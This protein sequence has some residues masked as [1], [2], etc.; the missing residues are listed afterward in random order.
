[1]AANQDPKKAQQFLSLQE[2]I[3]KANAEQERILKESVN[4]TGATLRNL[5]AQY[6]TQ[7]K[8]KASAKAASDYA[9]GFATASAD[10]NKYQA[11]IAANA[12]NIFKATG[13]VEDVQ[14][15]IVA[16]ESELVSIQ[17][18]G[19]AALVD[20]M[21]MRINVLK[22]SKQTLKVQQQS[23]KGLGTINDMLGDNV[24]SLVGFL[25]KLPGGNHLV[26]MMG[27]DKLKEGIAAALSEAAMVNATMGGGLKGATAGAKAFGKSLLVS[28][29][30]IALIAAGI[31]G[32][33]MVFKQVSHQ[34]H[35]LSHNTGLTYAQSKLLVKE[36]NKQVASLGNQ[37]S[38]QKDILAVQQES[39]KEFG[40]MGMMTTQQAGA[41][42]DM[43]IA[44]GY[45][46]Q[47]AAK[48]NNAFMSM[49]VTA[50][51]AASAQQ[52]LAAE[53][54]KAGVNVGA[55]TA[56]VAANAK[57][58]AKYFG[59]N[60]K[61]L[62]KAAIE[63]AKM[64]MS[65]ATMA[66]VSDSLLDFEN[67]ISAQFELQA[68]T[69]K[70]MNFDLARQLALEGDIA[71]ATAAVMDQVGSIHD[72]NKMDVL[73]RKKLAQATGMDVDELQK[74]LV[75]KDK[76]GD[77]TSDEL[78]SMNALGLSA[79][80]MANMSSEDLQNK[81]ASKQASE[82]TA[83][84]FAAMKAQLVNALMPAAEAI[85]GIFSALS[86][87]FKVLG[88]AL[89]IAF[90]PLTLAGKAL[91][92]IMGLMEKFKGVTMVIGGLVATEYALRN[93]MLIQSKA[94]AGMQMAEKTW[95]GIKNAFMNKEGIQA[96]V[97]NAFQATKNALQKSELGQLI[98]IG[99]QK[100]WQGVMAAKDLVVQGSIFAIEQGK[101]AI[102]Y[103]INTAK[104]IANVISMG[105]IGPLMASAGAAIAAAIPAIFTGFGMIPFGLGIPL[106]FAA[107]AGLIGL[108]G[109]MSKGDDV[110]SSPSGGSGYGSRV[111]FGPEGAISF[112]NKDTIVAGTD[113]FGQANDAMFAPKGALKMNDGA[114]GDM[115]DPPEAKIVG[116]TG[117]SVAK[118]SIGIS[119]AM[120][121]GMAPAFTAALA[122][123]M[124]IIGATIT[125][126]IV[127]GAAATAL[128]P[129][130]VLV[131]NPIIPTFEM[132]PVMMMG[133]L[134]GGLFG[135]GG[136][137]A[138]P[139]SEIVAKL[140][141]VKNAIQN[142][143]IN[144]DGKK[145]GAMTRL[146]DSFRRG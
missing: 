141:E 59:G 123:S 111:L 1:M 22:Q 65:L 137:E 92:G 112:N 89:K 72:F 95:L 85:M 57:S 27:L 8:I 116:I 144:M 78:A 127:A 55:V 135:G 93:K 96:G 133:S 52:D 25:G 101:L 56:D 23:A 110:M 90:M 12:K 88:V 130:P 10:A 42:S 107:V 128:I 108:I 66:K 74:S 45:G 32:L 99:A 40:I 120:A 20:S 76:M 61:A 15:A 58:T 7:E 2:S 73:E 100:A 84:A 39:V 145:V 117:E 67:S 126:A 54:M 35:E 31:A 122:M 79:S 44:F 94:K 26:K 29:G 105:A 119:A 82:K 51:E 21:K 28:L 109:S 146:A 14:K 33:V 50:D 91:K 142:M 104:T 114:I 86:P 106:A 124:P 97:I 81:L 17:K 140:D 138:D 43:G 46:A 24:D 48:L 70:Q 83:A 19:N 80:E 115:P 129:K 6:Q 49:G 118:L 68:M 38:Q 9:E 143:E 121:V 103:A 62:K 113:L 60:V 5:E 64:G 13:K 16:A 139:N 63:A 37:L 41:V 4:A 131:L 47:Q 134:L 3:S 77:L 132:N 53:A 136:D 18:S 11:M 87:L 102:Q 69:G 75:I 125:G 71:G 30:P 36:A 98:A 34:A